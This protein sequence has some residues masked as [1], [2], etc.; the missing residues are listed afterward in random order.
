MQKPG[1]VQPAED[2]V[3]SAVHA[4]QQA[5]PHQGPVPSAGVRPA[6]LRAAGGHGGAAAGPSGL[7]VHPVAAVRPG[8]QG[9][10]GDGPG[11]QG[12][13]IFQL[14]PL[15]EHRHAE[16]ADKGCAGGVSAPH[17]PP[18][19]GCGAALGVTGGAF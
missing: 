13:R 7:G 6:E 11:D 19:R 16:A 3:L 1:A 8:A 9:A 10:A 12:L 4:Q 2:P 5:L 15:R 18:A 14:P 17:G